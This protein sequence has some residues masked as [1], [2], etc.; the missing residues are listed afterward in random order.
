MGGMGK[1][2]CPCSSG[3]PHGQAGACPWH[4]ITTCLDVPPRRRGGFTLIELLVVVA[5]IGILVAVLLP[6]FATVRTQ[7]KN[8]ETMAQFNALATGLE[9]FRSETALGSTYPPSRSDNPGGG[10][11]ANPQGT[12]G[13]D[14]V[15]ATGA[16]LL[17]Q[18]MLGADLLGTPGFKD[19]GSTGSRNGLWWDDTHL[20]APRGN[21]PAGAYFV[22]PRSGELGHSRYGGAG[23]VDDKMR[24][25][26]TSLSELQETGG[27]VAFP[28]SL[29]AANIEATYDQF[30]FVDPWD[31]PILYYRANQVARLMLGTGAAPGIYDQGDNGL[32]AGAGAGM[33]G[34]DFGAGNVRERGYYH[35]IS[36]DAVPDPTDANFPGFAHFDDSFA[37]FI[38]DSSVQRVHQPVRKDSF[39]LV[40]AGPDAVY[41]TD[42]DVTNWSRDK[43]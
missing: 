32:I 16:H 35:R 31:R 13:G 38:H 42:D 36:N 18:A 15:L 34:I 12:D 8:A 19:F 14:T 24:A 39:L 23:F 20:G 37:R 10:T 3:D 9:Q 41:G 29:P 7:A 27:I 5:I 30:L 11:I 6:A 40:S 26:A 17:L 25:R 22:D 2:V 33:T 21:A 1:L 4:P 28:E 43:R